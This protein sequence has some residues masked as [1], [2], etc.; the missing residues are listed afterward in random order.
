[1][2]VCVSEQQLTTASMVLGHQARRQP[3][4]PAQPTD[5]WPRTRT[6][7]HAGHQQAPRTGW[8]WSWWGRQSGG[9]ERSIRL[10]SKQRDRERSR[11]RETERD[12]HTQ[13]QTD[14]QT[15]MLAYTRT[16][17]PVMHEECYVLLAVR[18]LLCSH[19]DVLDRFSKAT[20]ALPH[21]L[22]VETSKV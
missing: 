15:T 5:A 1:M 4:P 22:L 13:T 20:H 10:S 9:G 11:E 19:H 21:G 14:R 6:G 12:T 7:R 2:C 18:A 16:R 3:Q 17:K 8:R